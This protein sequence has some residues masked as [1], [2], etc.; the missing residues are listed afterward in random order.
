MLGNRFMKPFRFLVISCS[1]SDTSRM[2]ISSTK[3]SNCNSLHERSRSDGSDGRL[4][5]RNFDGARSIQDAAWLMSLEG[6]PDQLP[7]FPSYP[8]I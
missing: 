1:T 6:I 5:E 8:L 3:A 2:I 4:F 7:E